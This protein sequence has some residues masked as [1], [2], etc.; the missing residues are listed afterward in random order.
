MVVWKVSKGLNQASRASCY[1]SKGPVVLAQ[2]EHLETQPVSGS[3]SLISMWKPAKPENGTH[4]NIYVPHK[5]TGSTLK[6]DVQL[7]T[8]ES[9]WGGSSG[10]LDSMLGRRLRLR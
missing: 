7:G 6:T 10:V 9:P 2:Q 3:A 1:T 8:S 4:C 5:L